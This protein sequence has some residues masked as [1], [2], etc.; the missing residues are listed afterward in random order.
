MRDRAFGA[1]GLAI[2]AALSVAA[3]QRAPEAGTVDVHLL[4]FN[5]FHGNLE[6]PSGSNGRIGAMEAGGIEYLATHLARL[7]A[8]NPNT[9]VVSAGDN[10]GAAPLLSSMFHDEPTIEALGAAGLQVSAVGNHELDH[11]WWELY[12]MQKG[13]CHPVDGCQGGTTF[14]GAKFEFLSANIVV[15]PLRVDAKELAKSGWKSADNRPTTLFPPSVVKEVGG[16]KVGFIGLT[17]EGAPRIVAPAGVK[18]LSFFPEARTANVVAAG[19]RRQG[20]R[21]IV[22]LIHEGGKQEGDDPDACHSLTGA[23]LPIVQRM[24]ENIDVVVSGHTHR[25]YNC[26][27]GT[28]LVTSAESFGRLITDIDLRI[29]HR[30]GGVVS[31]SA[32]NVIVTRDVVKDAGETALL[33]RYRPFAAKIGNR[34][35]GSITASIL[36]TANEAGESALGDIVADSM[37]DAARDPERGGA[38]V[39]LMNPGGLRADLTRASAPGSGEAS[40]VTYSDAFNV[41]PFGNVVIVKTL[42]GDALR[43]LL[44]QQFDNPRPGQNTLLQVS[45]GFGYSYSLSRPP[46]HRVEPASITINGRKAE[47]AARYRVA[48]PDYLWSGGDG[49]TVAK[50]GSN[51][52]A[53]N[54]DVDVFAAYIGKHSPL[55]PGPQ[56]RLQRRP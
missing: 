41:L 25:A 32:H 49:L 53:G 14:D 29:D 27:I 4:A 26:T 56:N 11:G 12:R 18:G 36:R 28:K 52:N 47:P 24:S 31:K 2:L 33:D 16:V 39:A 44:E 22:V 45:N 35:V 46:G 17:L 6:P 8:S 1:L 9:I 42:S 51:P 7:K 48:M 38:V 34:P 10:I 55:G 30:T 5:D 50:E 3:V 54:L 15:D 21:A 23:I 20:V 40:A 43:R 37:L 13:G 19:L